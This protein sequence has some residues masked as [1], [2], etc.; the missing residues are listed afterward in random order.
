MSDDYRL[1]QAYTKITAMDGSSF[2]ALAKS[3]CS[4]EEFQ[5]LKGI[6]MKV[7]AAISDPQKAPRGA[8][9]V[10]DTIESDRAAAKMKRLTVSEQKKQLTEK[11]RKADKDAETKK[12]EADAMYFVSYIEEMEDE[13]KQAL[14]DLT[15]LPGK[16]GLQPF[17]KMSDEEKKLADE[18]PNLCVNLFRSAVKSLTISSSLSIWNAVQIGH[19]LEIAKEGWDKR[20]VL[21]QTQGSFKKWATNNFTVNNGQPIVKECDV[22]RYVTLKRL[23]YRFPKL[24]YV[25]SKSWRYLA[26][27][28][29]SFIKA[30]CLTETRW[31]FWSEMPAKEI[32][33][34]MAY[35]AHKSP[36][37]TYAEAM[38]W[39]INPIDVFAQIA[40]EHREAQRARLEEGRK[41]GEK[42]AGRG[43]DSD[44][45]SGGDQ[46]MVEG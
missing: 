37:A 18:D 8:Q 9:E 24:L 46:E 27:K 13:V 6:F 14:R 17:F 7:G 45:N 1:Q 44:E 31:R 5:A 19:I 32:C 34:G 4:V 15:T 2:A 3:T 39:E 20:S 33:A 40:E 29:S 41:A 11:R 28:A 12:V 16:P 23:C 38:Q 36:D 26:N 30:A 42:L 22:Y 21:G 25:S 35:P 10:L 43:S